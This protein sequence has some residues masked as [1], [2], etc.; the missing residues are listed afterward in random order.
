MATTPHVV[1]VFDSIEIILTDDVKPY[2][3]AYV[4]GNKR[5]IELSLGYSLIIDNFI[6]FYTVLKANNSD[7]SLQCRQFHTYLI[8]KISRLSFEEYVSDKE[9]N[10]WV[11]CKNLKKTYTQRDFDDIYESLTGPFALSTFGLVLGHEYVHHLLKHVPAG[12]M[13]ALERRK[14]ET[15]ADRGASNLLG[16]M[17]SRVPGAVILDVAEPLRS[18]DPFA[19]TRN[20]AATPCRVYYF[21]SIDRAFGIGAGGAWLD[22]IGAEFPHVK[23]RLAQLKKQMNVPIDSVKSCDVTLLSDEEL[24]G[25][26]P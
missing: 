18:R 21:I 1:D 24:F 14:V 23:Q 19:D 8:Q 11:Y 17:A 10:P 7:V 15:I 9:I 5:Y 16:E 25:V 3:A 12:P 6:K 26:K 4:T 20:Y 22:S 2:A 13:S